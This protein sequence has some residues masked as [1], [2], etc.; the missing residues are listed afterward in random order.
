MAASA[1]AAY[2]EYDETSPSCLRWIVSRG[3]AVAGM[4]AGSISVTEKGYR[5]WL[6]KLHG[7][8]RLVSHVIWSLKM[9]GP[10]PE[11]IDHINGDSTDNR[12]ENLRLV[13]NQQNCRN[14]KMRAD[15]SSGRT[16]LYLCETYA[17]GF[18]S[19]VTGKYQ[20]KSFA[21]KKYGREQ[22]IMMAVQ[23]RADNLAAMP[24]SLEYSSRHGA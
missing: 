22:A 2:F 3:R 8:S 19:D 12:I 9:G 15:N 20:R 11:Q 6:V 21:F 5:M 16:G 18:F 13:S 24:S 14:R 10:V 17:A 4:K 7:S 1:Y 23:W